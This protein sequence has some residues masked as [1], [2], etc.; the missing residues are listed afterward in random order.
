[1]PRDGENAAVRVSILSSVNI[2]E[3]AQSLWWP[4]LLPWALRG[5]FNASLIEEMSCGKQREEVIHIQA[6][7][8]KDRFGV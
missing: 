1:L 8:S 3:T 5:K 4:V 6:G 2:I 7:A